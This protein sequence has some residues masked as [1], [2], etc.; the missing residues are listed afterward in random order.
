MPRGFIFKGVRGV[1]KTTTAY[2][3]ARALMC[4]GNDPLG[5]GKC[6]SCQFIDESGLEAH[7]DFVYTVGALEP[8]VDNAR[9]LLERVNQPASQMSKRR[10]TIID[11]AHRLSREA[12]DAYLAPLEEKDTSSV[13]IFVTNEADKIP[14]TI[15]SR[16]MPMSFGRVHTDVIKGLLAKLATDNGIDY[17]LEALGVI[18]RHFKGIVREAVSTLGMCASMGRITV[19]LVSMVLDNALEDMCLN[20]FLNI[21]QNNQVEAVKLIDEAGRNYNASKVVEVLFSIYARTPWAE[22]GSAYAAIAAKLPNAKEVD[23]TFLRWMSGQHLPSDALPLLVY[24]L[25][26]TVDV[27]LNA[28][29]KAKGGSKVSSAPPRAGAAKPADLEKFMNEVI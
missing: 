5:C 25:V 19:D 20:V 13:F 12:W 23:D 17:E 22:P 18:A 28:V 8:G 15:Q 7:P 24:E 21:I 6:P 14:A 26:N 11:E 16:C 27:P 9:M 4:T 3:F 10:V 1:G 29:S 2:I